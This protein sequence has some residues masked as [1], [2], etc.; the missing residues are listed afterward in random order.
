MCLVRRIST[1]TDAGWFGR[2]VKGLKVEDVKAPVEQA[3]DALA[4]ERRRIS[5]A[6]NSILIVGATYESK[7]QYIIVLDKRWQK[8]IPSVGHPVSPVQSSIL[9][10]EPAMF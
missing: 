8:A 6:R 7:S 9:F 3:A 1:K 4:P 10:F 2:L 5:R